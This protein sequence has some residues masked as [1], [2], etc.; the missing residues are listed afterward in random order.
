MI[1]LSI[2]R[3]VDKDVSELDHVT[4]I[5]VDVLSKQIQQ[6]IQQREKEIPKAE[7]IIK[8]MTKDFLE[9]EKKRKLAPNIHHFK[10][11]LRTWNAMRCII[12]TEKIST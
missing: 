1:D 3:N 6:T 11:V 5:D 2:P 12:F 8:E 7:K 10:A 9:W 4:L